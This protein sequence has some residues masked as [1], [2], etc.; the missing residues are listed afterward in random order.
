[1]L[2]YGLLASVTVQLW[3]IVLG[4]AMWRRAATRSI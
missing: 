4:G 2:V 1:V 3:S